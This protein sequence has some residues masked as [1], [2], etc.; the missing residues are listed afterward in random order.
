MKYTILFFACMVA[1]LLVATLENVK[2]PERRDIRAEV[3]EQLKRIADAEER[4]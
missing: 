4:Q 1:G 3:V 2:I